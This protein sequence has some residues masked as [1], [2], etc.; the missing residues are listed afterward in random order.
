MI[1]KAYLEGEASREAIKEVAGKIGKTIGNTLGPSGRNYFIPSGITNDGAT[2]LNNMRF[3]DE[4]KDSLAMAFGEIALRADK[5]AGD[6]TTTATV[7]GTRLAIDV[8]EKVQDLETPTPGSTPVMQLAR[9]LEEEK[10]KVIALLEVKAVPTDTL[11]KLTNVAMTAMEDKEGAKIVA[12]AIWEG[13]KN[14]MPVMEDGCNGKIEKDV[15]NGVKFGFNIASSDMFT[16][17]GRAELEN[18]GVLVVNHAFEQY[19]E[20]SGIMSQILQ[21][22]SDINGLV[23]V[24]NNFS[25]PFTRQATEV[26][27]RSPFKFVLMQRKNVDNDVYEDV[28]AYVNAGFIDTHPKTGRK[29][30]EL[31]T[32]DIGRVKKVIAREKEVIFIGGQGEEALTEGDTAYNTRLGKRIRDLE[33]MLETEKKDKKDIEQ[34]IAILKGGIVT[35]Y[36]DA[37]TAAEK[38]YLKLKVEDAMNSCRSALNEG[39]VKGGGTQLA[40]IAGELGEDSLM[41]SALKAPYRRIQQNHGEDLS[42]DDSVLDS[43][44]VIKSAVKNAV[45][46]VKLL[47]TTE[48][49]IA[50][51]QPSMVEELR[52]VH[53]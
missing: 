52:K 8:L 30:S 20:M 21:E 9:Q 33:E 28:A 26:G 38:Y 31:T 7:I 17:T 50:D 36:V 15:I 19:S 4:C 18:M 39:M 51:V 43:L 48:G 5:E 6:G 27:R 13:G 47:I 2:I 42:I 35:V 22:K 14:T 11:E 23:I 25:I 46:V 34:R 44:T 40:D 12:E 1:T 16:H 10:D 49:V 53:E 24:A 29:L 32:K 41:D 37:Q 45:S 3:A